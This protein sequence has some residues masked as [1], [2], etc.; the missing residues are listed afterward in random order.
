[1]EATEETKGEAVQR[2]ILV[3]LRELS[4][5]VQN[6][7]DVIGMQSPEDIA[8]WRELMRTRGAQSSEDAR[9]M[10]IWQAREGVASG[11]LPD[12]PPA[13]KAKAGTKKRG[14]QPE[15]AGPGEGGP[16]KK[17]KAA[18][19]TRDYTI[20]QEARQCHMVEESRLYGVLTERWGEQEFHARVL[21]V[22]ACRGNQ[23]KGDF[24]LLVGA[25]QMDLDNHM[26]TGPSESTTRRT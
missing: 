8:R 23:R 12:L 15:A 26:Q 16:A 21:A 18:K 19:G 22:R 7:A 5:L 11:G 13:K 4:G 14:R 2:Q 9:R 24:D 3:V 10:R 25:L 17:A 1:M 6:F 20:A